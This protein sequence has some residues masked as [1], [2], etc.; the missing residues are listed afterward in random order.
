[1]LRLLLVV[2][3]GILVQCYLPIPILWLCGIGVVSVLLLTILPLI[4]LQKP[5]TLQWL[6]G[7]AIHFILI[8][9][10]SVLV[11]TKD[12]RNN[13]NHV[14]PAP[15]STYATVLTLTEPLIAKAKSYKANATIR[16][17]IQDSIQQATVGN[18]IL[19]IGKDSVQPTLG[20]GS[21]ILISQV[22]QPIR[23]SGNPGAF[24]YNRQCLYSNNIT[25]QVYL[26]PHDYV[27]LPQHHYN[28]FKQ[29]I[30]ALR[31]NLLSIINTYITSPKEKG[32]AEALLIGYR[33]DLDKELIQAY[34]NTGTIHVI[35]ISGLHLG[36][37]Y[38]LLLFL[39]KPLSKYTWVVKWVQP[40]VIIGILWLF[41]ILAGAAP[42]ILRSA[43]M[44]T[45][46]VIANCI[47]RSTSIYNTMA[48]SALII[49]CINPFSLWD[50]GFQL[51]YSA[52]LSIIIFMK[53]IYHII[54]CKYKV[55]DWLWQLA[56]VTF[57]AQIL[58]FPIVLYH[59]HQFPNLFLIT[60]MVA[61]PLS[62]ILLGGTLLL[63]CVSWCT[64]IAAL[65]GQALTF[66][67][68][69]MNSVI[70]WCSSMTYAI[71]DYISFD[72]A[73]CLLLYTIIIT[74]AYWLLK[75]YKPAC[76]VALLTILL[77]CIHYA[78]NTVHLQ[79][80][81]KLVVYS[82]P[83]QQATDI[84]I[85]NTYYYIG[86][87]IVQ[88]D[89][90]LHNFHL[91]PAHI[92][93]G[94]HKGTYIGYYNAYPLVHACN[95][96]ILLLDASYTF[97]T[98]PSIDVLI[99]SKNAKIKLEKLLQKYNIKQVVADASNSDK[100]IAQWQLHCNTANVPLYNTK[101][102]GAYIQKL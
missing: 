67:I 9:L 12:V 100:V 52:V 17:I 90:F 76:K 40:V 18:V 101:V 5:I 7:L 96:N 59:F 33:D 88:E 44:F 65:L 11:Y 42:S 13:P 21:T 32:V 8:V 80:Q 95:K 89:E 83:K 49:L 10:G 71:T 30:Y 66:S 45:C 27:V 69:C 22:L 35:A 62:T 61:V 31:N 15:T 93:M 70:T 73:Q 20:Y 1:M 56:S 24:D 50:V 25:H 2:S 57:A 74:L 4:I 28:T 14:I 87:S 60:N 3:I 77:L 51:S 91:K 75:K 29:W 54:Y 55:I 53:P 47:G 92:A 23:S 6:R 82:I 16:Y 94:V 99:L 19:Y 58:T 72:M 43:I 78:Y 102:S 37:I 63:L 68:W 39:F 86:D 79:H 36:F 34:S 97:D 26:K 64:P 38:L 46:I 41:S 85:G 84:I 81:R 48:T 98:L